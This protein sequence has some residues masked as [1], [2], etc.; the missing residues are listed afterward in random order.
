MNATKLNAPSAVEE[1]QRL[2][3][4]L[5]LTLFRRAAWWAMAFVVFSV[6]VGLRVTQGMDEWFL[7]TS[8]S[9]GWDFLDLVSSFVSLLGDPE[10]TGAV[11]LW[12]AFKGWRGRGIKGL[13]V[14][15]LFFGVAFE[16]A[17]KYAVP[18]LGPPAMWRHKQLPSL[19]HLSTPYSF[20]S[21]HML[22]SAF[23]VV[24]LTNFFPRWRQVGWGF[25]VLMAITRIY[26]NEHWTSDVIGGC[27]LGLAF[28][29]V[30]VAIDP[31]ASK[32]TSQQPAALAKTAS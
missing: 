22:R 15:L 12:L 24:Y 13:A 5:S 11:T 6:L 17:M 3:S 1:Q 18:H 8:Q 2:I 19:V 30:A 21:G 28:A 10:I 7:T 25:V 26:L 4:A 31:A 16:L 27:L 23:L 20:P 32:A 9:F 29:L 14:L